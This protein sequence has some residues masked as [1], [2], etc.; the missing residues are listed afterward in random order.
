MA[1][2]RVETALADLRQGKLILLTDDVGA[3]PCAYLFCGASSISDEQLCF[4]VNHGRGIVCAAMSESRVKQ[5]HLPMMSLK[6]SSPASPDF[7]A[8]VEARRGVG[9]GISAS[10]RART[11]RTLAGTRDPRRDLVMPGHIFPISAK[12]GGVLV[13]NGIPEAAVDLLRLAELVPVAAICHCLDQSGEF[14]SPEQIEVLRKNHGLAI[15]SLSE[16]VAHRMANESLVEKVAESELPT[17]VAG[18]FRAAAFRSLHDGAE[19]FSLVKGDIAAA[20]EPVLVRVQAE[21]RIGDLIG[22]PQLPQR[23]LILG[24]LKELQREGC[25]IFIYVRHPR[26]GFLAKQVKQIADG[27]PAGPPLSALRQTGIGAQ[28]LR[29]LGA[30]KIRLLTSSKT[31]L[32]G[33]EAFGIEIAER[34]AFNAL[35]PVRGSDAVSEPKL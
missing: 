18:T 7:T 31:P 12:S 35:D 16:L 14:Q 21:N 30:R 27:A 3:H 22:P 28:I 19:H 11:L 24:A 25:G 8:S 5:L 2:S 20:K 17:R 26:K 29:S 32:A 4:M 15:V 1:S 13:R 34:V 10:D 33:L 6:S 23:G 9:T